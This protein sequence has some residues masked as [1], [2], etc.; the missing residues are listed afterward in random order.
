MSIS[1][2]LSSPS[3][4]NIEYLISCLDH[5]FSILIFDCPLVF[6]VSEAGMGPGL[7]PLAQSALAVSL[8]PLEAAGPSWGQAPASQPGHWALARTATKYEQQSVTSDKYLTQ[9][10]AKK[11][12]GCSFRIRSPCVREFLAETIGMWR[13]TWSVD[14]DDDDN[15]GTYILVL[16][17]AGS[18]AQSTLSLGH[19]GDFFSINWGWVTIIPC[20]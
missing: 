2:N 6:L 20:H 5:P 17:G 7:S 1:Y 10:M 9:I 19:K 12:S 3:I 16:F 4:L 14:T 18:I 8:P 11:R 15:S 13:V